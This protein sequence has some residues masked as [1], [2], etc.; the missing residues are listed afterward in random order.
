MVDEEDGAM[1]GSGKRRS[2]SLGNILYI[3]HGWL[4]GWYRWGWM[5]LLLICL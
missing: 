1:I 3:L 5:G 2:R 4:A